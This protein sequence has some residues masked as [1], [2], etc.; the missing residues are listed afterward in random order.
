MLA[1]LVKNVQML[2]QNIRQTKPMIAWLIPGS[3]AQAPAKI[4]FFIY[5]GKPRRKKGNRLPV[6]PQLLHPILKYPTSPIF[7]MLSCL[8]CMQNKDLDIRTP[9]QAT[10][11]AIRAYLLMLGRKSAMPSEACP[12]YLTYEAHHHDDLTRHPP[13]PKICGSLK[14]VH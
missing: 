7:K 1:L 4:H 2:L 5:F 14:E 10:T 13:Q 8:T 11:P 6:L 3:L 12:V 9:K